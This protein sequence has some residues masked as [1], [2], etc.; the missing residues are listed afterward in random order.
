[1]SRLSLIQPELDAIRGVSGDDRDTVREILTDLSGA[2]NN[3]RKAAEKWATLT[4]GTRKKVI[5]GLPPT[6]RGFMDRLTLVA[7]DRLHPQLY[8]AAGRAA[9]L[10]GKLPLADQDRYLRERIPVAILKRGKPDVLLM[11]V[12]EMNE[13]QRKQVFK[14]S[15]DNGHAVLVRDVA[16]Q[17]AYLDD[18]ARR[19]EREQQVEHDATVID[20]P[21]RW[22]VQKGKAIINADRAKIGL[23]LKDARLLLKDLSPLE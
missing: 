1:M 6:W 7:E 8:A 16:Q 20:R 17:T 18:L 12:E 4:P 2:A 13:E 22:R 21:G 9:T 10:L 19:R 23:T 11:D 14:E 3:V 15:K 5:E